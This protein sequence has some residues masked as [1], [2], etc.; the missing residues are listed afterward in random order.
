MYEPDAQ[1][2]AILHG[3]GGFFISPN[4]QGMNL[5][6]EPPPIKSMHIV[7]NAL[8]RA[9]GISMEQEGPHGPV[10]K[11]DILYVDFFQ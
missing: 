6:R 10:R 11:R 9:I 3:E 8:Q 1:A 7:K 4:D 5:A 2:Q